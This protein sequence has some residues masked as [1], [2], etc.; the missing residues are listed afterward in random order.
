VKVILDTNVLLAA[1]V[2]QGLCHELFRRLVRARAMVTSEPLLEELEGVIT[3]KMHLTPA[4]NRFLTEL[5]RA[6]ERVCPGTLP[7]PVCRD[8]DDD[9]V[10]ATAV[11]A[12]ADVIV[13]GDADLLIL[14][15]YEGIFILSP[16]QFL[17][18][19]DRSQPAE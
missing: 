10:L 13:T 6:V 2:T 14:K 16:R 9:V 15:E 1:L 17:Q 3:R 8:P 7:A 11:A 5:R 12:H 19:L 18:W 4:V